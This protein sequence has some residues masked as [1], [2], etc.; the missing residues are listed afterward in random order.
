MIEFGIDSNIL[1]TIRDGRKTIEG[2]L[3]R[4]KF[5]TI[6]VGDVISVREDFYENDVIQKSQLDALRVKVT[7]VQKYEDFHEMLTDLGYKSAIPNAKSV[8]E[9]YNEYLRYYSE[10]SQ[11]EYG[12]LAILFQ[13]SSLKV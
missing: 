3:A 6:K 13:V 8:N 4:D 2:R 5:L 1:Q 9:A 10:A 7:A 11:K 12:V